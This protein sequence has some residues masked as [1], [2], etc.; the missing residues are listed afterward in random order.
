LQ[1]YWHNQATYTSSYYQHIHNIQQIPPMHVFT[2]SHNQIW[3]ISHNLSACNVLDMT[4][5]ACGT[6][7][8]R[9]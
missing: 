4:L 7:R 5:H 6:I 2:K 3:H 9:R 1:V 8:C